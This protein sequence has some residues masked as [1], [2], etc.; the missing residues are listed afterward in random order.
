MPP[1]FWCFGILGPHFPGFANSRHLSCTNQ[2]IQTL[3]PRPY[4]LTPSASLMGLLPSGPIIPSP[5]QCRTR[6]QT[7]R[8]SPQV[9]E[10]AGSIQLS[11][12]WTWLSLLPCDHTR[13]SRPRA[14]LPPLP[15]LGSSAVA[16]MGGVFPSTC[17]GVCEE[18]TVF[19]MA[20]T[21]W[22]AGVTIPE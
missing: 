11:Q 19:L 4:T 1:F 18:R 13:G 21:P 9:A 2:P 7:S 14:P 6:I 16:S 22:P 12:S 10:P 8:D 15:Q 5:N 3:D 20:A 17:L